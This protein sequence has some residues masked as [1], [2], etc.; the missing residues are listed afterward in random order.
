MTVISVQGTP[1]VGGLLFFHDCEPSLGDFRSETLEGLRASS[2]RTLPKYLYDARGSALF[3]DITAL[4]EYYPTRTELGLLQQ[5]AGD[6]ADYVG[7]GAGVIELGSGSSVKVRIV[8]DALQ[9]PALY[10]AQDISKDHLANAAREIA[11]DYDTLDVGAVCSDFT[12]EFDLPGG[13]FD[14]AGRRIVFF[15][16]STIGNFEPD[17]AAKI[18]RAARSLLRPG[19]VF[20]LGCDLVKDPEVMVAAY[21]DRAGVTREFILNILSRI[22][23]EL[24]GDLDRGAFTYRA[25]WNPDLARIEMNIESRADQ[26]FHVAG[27][28]VTMAAGERINASNSHKFT[29]DRIADAGEKAGFVV[30]KQW[31][32]ARFPFALLLMEAVAF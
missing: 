20:L 11:R 13:I 8:L 21:D 2:K 25:V 7:P 26:T 31:V 22:N 16:G 9:E 17:V 12:Q 6:I 29:L 24:D 27:E 5:A 30:R 4:P 15:P 23:G 10:V 1:S 18:W 28:A 3:D 19:D 32:D 14:G